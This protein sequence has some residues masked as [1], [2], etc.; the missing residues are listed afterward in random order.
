MRDIDHGGHGR[1]GQEQQ[2]NK[3]DIK[4]FKQTQPKRGKEKKGLLSRKIGK[5]CERI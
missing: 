1:G 2:Y 4:H 5:S 3:K